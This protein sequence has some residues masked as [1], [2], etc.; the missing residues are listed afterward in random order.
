M[1]D[2]DVV[3]AARVVVVV[4]AR[5]VV[6]VAARVVVVVAAR[7][8]ADKVAVETGI[9]QMFPPLLCF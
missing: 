6:V 9:R 5:V 2:V 7:V 8:V 3:V 1:V 4:A